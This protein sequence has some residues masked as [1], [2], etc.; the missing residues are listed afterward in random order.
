MPSNGELNALIRLLDDENPDVRGPVESRLVSLGPDLSHQLAES[1][2]ELSAPMRSRLTK[3]LRPAPRERLRSEWLAPAGG[4][5]AMIDDWDQ[6][7]AMLRWI[8]DFLHDGISVRLPLSDALDRLAQEA[9]SNGATNSRELR[10]YL[11]VDDRLVAN[12][13]GFDQPENSD[14]AWCLEHACSNQIGLS[15]IY[16][17]VARRLEMLVEGVDFPGHFLTRIYEE[18]YPLIIDC[19]EKG[20]L[21]LQSTLLENP[22]LSREQRASAQATATTGAIICRVLRNLKL[23]MQ[24][25]DRLDDAQLVD[26]LL[27]SLI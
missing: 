4:A 14:L 2:L 11:F 9:D 17:L 22:D 12:R 1:S 3:Q 8:S 19:F 27:D 6:L 26:E 18:G 21:H 20:S 23:A 24:K 7:E 16:I 15:L 13:T 10:G 5:T 25:S